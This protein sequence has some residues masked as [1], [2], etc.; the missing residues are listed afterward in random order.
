MTY[1]YTSDSEQSLTLYDYNG[2]NHAYFC[3]ES[4]LDDLAGDNETGSP[5]IHIAVEGHIRTYSRRDAHITSSMLDWWYNQLNESKEF[6]DF[7]LG[8]YVK[9]K[10]KGYYSVEIDGEPMDSSVYG[11]ALHLARLPRNHPH[12]VYDTKKLV[13]DGVS[14]RTAYRISINHPFDSYINQIRIAATSDNNLPMGHDVNGRSCTI[15]EKYDYANAL[16]QRGMAWSATDSI[17]SECA[18]QDVHLVEIRP[19]RSRN[20]ENSVYDDHCTYRVV[21]ETGTTMINAWCIKPEINTWK[22]YVEFVKGLEKGE[23]K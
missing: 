5:L 18:I 10:T 7:G 20:N 4:I 8:F 6:A 15:G 22:K 13:D 17:L 21:D 9:T 2:E 19:A 1:T 3:F 23:R 12:I 11:L 16:V 14:F